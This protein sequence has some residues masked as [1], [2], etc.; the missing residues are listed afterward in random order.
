MK[1]RIAIVNE[2]ASLLKS[3][4]SLEPTTKGIKRCRVSDNDWQ[5]LACFRNV[6]S[7]MVLDAFSFQGDPRLTITFKTLPDRPYANELATAALHLIAKALEARDDTAIGEM[8]LQHAQELLNRARQLH[9][10]EAWHDV[11]ADAQGWALE[12]ECLSDQVEV[13]KKQPSLNQKKAKEVQKKNTA[14]RNKKLRKEIK[15]F[16]SQTPLGTIYKNPTKL[17]DAIWP[18]INAAQE[19]GAVWRSLSALEVAKIGKQT[20]FDQIQEIGHFKK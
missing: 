15:L 4:Y 20:V 6:I 11:G 7:N 5:E 2:L 14:E 18:E 16:Y 19:K 10:G 12:N 17:T 3:F 8:Y 1:Q 13:L 9:D